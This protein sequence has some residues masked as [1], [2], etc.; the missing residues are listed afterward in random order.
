MVLTE[1]EDQTNIL[2][3]QTSAVVAV[4]IIPVVVLTLLIHHYTVSEPTLGA[5]KE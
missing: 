2:W 3:E 5:V 1:F 4:Q